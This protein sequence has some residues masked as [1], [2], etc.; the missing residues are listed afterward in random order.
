ML[1]LYLVLAWIPYCLAAKRYLFKTCDQSGF[2]NRNRYYASHVEQSPYSLDS[3]SC[4]FESGALY[5]TLLKQLPNG[6]PAQFPLKLSVLKDGQFRIQIDEQTRLEKNINLAREQSADIVRKERYNE[7]ADWALVSDELPLD[8]SAKFVPSD[9]KLYIEY[10]PDHSFTAT[11]NF[12]PFQLSFAVNGDIQIVLNENG[13]FNM[14]H[15]RPRPSNTSEPDPNAGLYESDTGKWDESFGGFTDSK[16]RGPESVALDISFKGFSHVYGIPEH[17]D[18][19]NL[20][21]TGEQGEHSD[22]YHLFNVDI[23]EYEVNSTMSTYGA[24]P[25]MQAH[26]KGASVGVF[27]LNGADTWV[28]ISRMSSEA[29]S[30]THDQKVLSASKTT[31][32][33]HWISEAGVL[34]LF[35]F[36]GPTPKDVYRQYS[37]LTGGTL[38]PQLSAIGY[39]QCRWNYN[40]EEDVLEVSAKFDEHNIPVDVI[41]LDI[42]YTDQV[43]YFTWHPS[44][45][46]HPQ[47]MLAELDKSKRKLV[48][49]I[50][51]HIKIDDDYFVY[52]HLKETGTYLRN[53]AGEQFEGECWS[54]HSVWVDPF[55]PD[56]RKYWAELHALGGDFAG[57]ASNIWFWNDMN[58]PSVFEGAETTA[59][60][61][62]IHYDGWEHRDVHNIFGMAYH[63]S[64]YDALIARHKGTL[65]PFILTRSFFAGSQRYGPM[66]TGDNAATWDFLKV[67]IPMLL[68]NGIAG[69]PFSGVDV[70]GFFDNPSPELLTRWY[71]AAVFY[72]FFRA[73]AH[74]DTKRREPYLYDEPY[75]SLMRDAVNL[76]YAFSPAAY[77]AFYRAHTEGMPILRPLFVEYPDAENT[78]GVEDHFVLGDTGLLVRPVTEE[79][80]AE[81][82]VILPDASIYYDFDTQEVFQGPTKITVQTPLEKIPIFARGGHIIP[83]RHRERRSL[84]LA[85]FD[86]FTLVVYV[87]ENGEAEG[88]HY[89]DDFKSY[90]YQNGMYAYKDLLFKGGRLIS[91]DV[92]GHQPNSEFLDSIEELVIEKVIVIGLETSNLSSEALIKENGEESTAEII[93]NSK[94]SSSAASEI[95][96]RNPRV[97]AGGNWEI[98]LL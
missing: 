80:A 7:A 13:F 73:H 10:G 29:G 32:L 1:L 22:P 88:K 96:I 14:E 76:R 37:S 34:D 47:N 56:E 87:D 6:S 15:W 64:T 11:I 26:R 38:M 94:G 5:A 44:N 55:N 3:A 85:K 81:V 61:D 63:S 17:A 54:G 89:I 4:R 58:E 69:M 82:Q 59:P 42:A 35:V 75:L 27:W 66:W 23:F 79:N 71:Q 68:T 90:E 2:C 48:T 95:L 46:P 60:R 28:D 45:F 43:K 20:R 67:S 77:T 16:T 51:P 19:L 40:S 21:S 33:T 52:K 18:S 39:H 70:G 50:D 92:E 57:N 30:D 9:S 24:I 49:I 12:E 31:T 78:F 83:Q 41:W 93:I 74:I 98:N 72:P 86:P 25:F 97:S 84:E 53:S 62:A 91:Q 8:T 65:R 36:L